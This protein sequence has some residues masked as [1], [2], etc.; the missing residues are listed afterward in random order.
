[1]EKILIVDDEVDICY[2]LSRNLNRKNFEA[3]FV[4]SLR[5]AREAISEKK[6]SILLLDNHL[7]DGLGMDFASEIKKVYPGLKIVMITAHDT[8]T[9]RSNAEKNGIDCFLSKPFMMTD[10]FKAIEKIQGQHSN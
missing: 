4:N 1:M 8:P 6:P 10:V 9:D 3:S 2:F 5:E 7:P